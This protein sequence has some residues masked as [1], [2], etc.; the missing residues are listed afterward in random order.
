YLF[1]AEDEGLLRFASGAVHQTIYFPEVKA[2]HICHPPLAEQQRIVGVLHDAFAGLATAQAHAEKNFQSARAIFESHLHFVFTQNGDGWVGKKLGDLA[3]LITKG[4]TPTSAQHN[5]V[6]DGINFVK[7]ESL[8]AT[9]EF[10]KH[11][12]AHIT[13]ECHEALKKS[14]LQSGDILFSIAGALGR[15]AIVSHDILPAN[16]NQALAII[17]LKKDA[18]L[19]HRFILTV[20]RTGLVL[21]QIAKAKGGVAQENLS[22]AQLR[23]FDILIPPL[24]QQ[25]GIVMSLDALHTETQRLEVL[26]LQKQTALAELKKSLLHQAFS[27]AL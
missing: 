5:F 18:G 16:T 10:L 9:G 15:T 26:Y 19:L 21:D 3:E 27:G 24:A 4:T 13:P 11:K 12:L 6:G 8:S 2:F 20:L 22:L 14:Q 25:Q 17:R 1:I 23:D 7:V